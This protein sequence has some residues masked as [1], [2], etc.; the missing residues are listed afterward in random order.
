MGSGFKFF[1]FLIEPEN[2]NPAATLAG[3]CTKNKIIYFFAQTT[4]WIYFN[5]L[6][7]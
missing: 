3:W 6:I 4:T 7:L 2:S 1:F 5:I